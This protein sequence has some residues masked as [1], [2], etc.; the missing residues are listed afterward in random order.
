MFLR[1][2]LFLLICAISTS[3][4]ACG[5]EVMIRWME[6][7][8]PTSFP[9]LRIKL[10][11]PVPTAACVFGDSIAAPGHTTSIALPDSTD[12]T[13]P[14]DWRVRPAVDERIWFVD[15]DSSRVTISRQLNGSRGRRFPMYGDIVPESTGCLIDH[16]DTGAIWS[17]YEPDVSAPESYRYL[18]FGDAIIRNGRW[19]SVEIYSPSPEARLNAVRV[20]TTSLLGPGI[21]LPFR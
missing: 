20:L 19:Y 14:D 7:P 17:L 12:L 8:P 1:Q 18:A 21:T 4:S 11:G 15:G 3:A 2:I 13:L 10:T 9:A 5:Q 6:T 16:G